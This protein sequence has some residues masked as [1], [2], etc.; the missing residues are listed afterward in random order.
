MTAPNEA[1]VGDRSVL[2]CL[3]LLVVRPVASTYVALQGACWC[4]ERGFVRPRLGVRLRPRRRVAAFLEGSRARKAATALSF[5]A[6]GLLDRRRGRSLWKCRRHAA[7]RLTRRQ[8]PLKAS[9][10]F[11]SAIRS[12]GSAGVDLATPRD[13]E[14]IGA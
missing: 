6:Q 11:S 14:R 9:R 3:N 12:S 4:D 10:A 2:D 5:A 1:P 13:C 7:P 8:S